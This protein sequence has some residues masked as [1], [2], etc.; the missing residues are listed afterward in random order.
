MQAPQGSEALEVRIT[1]WFFRDRIQLPDWLRAEL[2]RH[3][4]CALSGGCW[5]QLMSS[6]PLVS[7][8]A[9]TLPARLKIQVGVL[10]TLIWRWSRPRRRLIHR[11][12]S[13]L[14]AFGIA[15]HG[16]D[17]RYFALLAGRRSCRRALVTRED[18]T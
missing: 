2:I 18:S 1:P 3:G 7:R 11:S 16:I 6:S 5:R 15:T 10:Q 13:R 8:L 12:A 4:L 9:L 17:G 14:Y